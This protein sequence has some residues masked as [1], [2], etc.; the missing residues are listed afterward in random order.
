MFTI[1]LQIYTAAT[2]IVVIKS[3]Y[4]TFTCCVTGRPLRCPD[5][6]VRVRVCWNISGQDEV[7]NRPYLDLRSVLSEIS[8]KT[9]MTLATLS[10]ECE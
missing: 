4:T 3:I 10:T 5:W 8:A 9:Q 6:V 1:D 2:Q 7:R